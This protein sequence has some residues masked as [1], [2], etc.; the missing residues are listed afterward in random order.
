[1]ITIKIVFRRGSAAMTILQMRAHRDEI[2]KGE[3]MK[4]IQK[5][6]II[7]GETLMEKDFR[8]QSFALTPCFR[9]ASLF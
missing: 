1:M 8:K 3:I 2:Q 9:R 4:E 6:K 7:D 5:L